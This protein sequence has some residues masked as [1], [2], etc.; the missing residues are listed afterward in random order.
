M[1]SLRKA[2][3]G[4][5]KDCIYDNKAPGTW[6]QQVAECTSPDCTLWDVRPKPRS[7]EKDANSRSKNT[8]ARDSRGRILPNARL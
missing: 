6:L 4:K 1:K 3:N 5:C 8:I 7:F 2:I